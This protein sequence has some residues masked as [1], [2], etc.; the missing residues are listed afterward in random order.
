LDQIIG[1][2]SNINTLSFSKLKRK[3]L[4]V[5]CE[6]FYQGALKKLD[7]YSNR[8]LHRQHL[9]SLCGRSIRTGPY[10]AVFFQDRTAATE[11]NYAYELW[12]NLDTFNT[13]YLQPRKQYLNI[14][15]NSTQVPFIYCEILEHLII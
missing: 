3:I 15:S 4:T 1:F 7:S 11:V 9:H 13:T 2:F 14:D 5:F 6:R 8:Q 12:N 10:I